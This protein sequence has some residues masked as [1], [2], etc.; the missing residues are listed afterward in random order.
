MVALFD[1]AMQRRVIPSVTVCCSTFS[2]R[3]LGESFAKLGIQPAWFPFQSQRQM[4][5]VH[6]EVSKNSDFATGYA[7]SFPVGRLVWVEV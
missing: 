6:S 4:T 7:L 2:I 3:S 1:P 5:G